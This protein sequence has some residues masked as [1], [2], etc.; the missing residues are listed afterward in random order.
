MI[1]IGYSGW[2]RTFGDISYKAGKAKWSLEIEKYGRGDKSGITFGLC[3]DSLFNTQKEK[4]SFDYSGD[5]NVDGFYGIGGSQNIYN[6]TKTESYSLATGDKFD[7]ELNFDKDVFKIFKNG[8][9]IAKANGIKDKVLRPSLSVY[10][11]YDT[12]I[13]LVT[14]GK[15][16]NVDK[17]SFGYEMK[18]E[19]VEV[20]NKGLTLKKLGSNGWYRT[21]AD[22]FFN[23]G[24]F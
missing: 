7:F 2:F 9:E 15:K 11:Q 24:T 14:S 3:E 13:K 22:S 8:K 10:Y 17:F 16:Q 23:K 5:I 12:I 20:S 18:G 19:V 21:F 4:T 6:M 1:K